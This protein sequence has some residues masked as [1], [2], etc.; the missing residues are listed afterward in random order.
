MLFW[1]AQTGHMF[2]AGSGSGQAACWV[3]LAVTGHPPLQAEDTEVEEAADVFEL[4]SFSREISI[5]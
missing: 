3:A 1:G 5:K 2:R 4:L